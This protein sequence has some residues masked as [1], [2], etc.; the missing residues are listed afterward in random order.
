MSDL[1]GAALPRFEDERL[2]TGRGRYVGDLKLPGM[3]FVAFAR[4]GGGPSRVKHVGCDRARDLTGVVGVYTT[5]DFPELARPLPLV[6]PAGDLRIRMPSPLASDIVRFAGEAVAVVVATS[7]YAAAD[8]AAAIEIECDELPAVVDV[9]AARNKDAPLVHD[10]VQGN[11]AGTVDVGFGDIDAAFANAPVVARRVLRAA[12]MACAA[13]EPR[14]IAAVPG[15][16][17]DPVLT[18]YD[19]TQAPHAIRGGIARL[20]GLKEDQVRV[21]APDVGGGF[22]PKG[23]LYPEE[24]VLAVLALHLKRPVSWQ[25]TRRDDLMTTYQ[26]RGI[27]FDAE[28]AAEQDGRVR[29]LRVRLT[30]DLGAYSATAMIVPQNSAQ[31]LLGP[32]RWP[33]VKFTIEGIYTHKAPLT[34]LRGGGREMGVWATERMFDHLAQELG[35]DP[36]DVRALNVLQPQDFPYETGYPARGGSGTIA[37]DSG[38]YPGALE[39]CKQLVGYDK[40]MTNQE[41]DRKDGIY[42][43]VA[44]TLF[45]E[46]T[47]MASETARADLLPDGRV[48]LRIG[49]PSTGQGHATTMRQMFAARFGIE[50]DRIDYVSGDTGAVNEG[51]G[52]F[53]SRMAIIAGNAAAMAGRQLRAKVFDIAA[54]M[55]EAAPED[56]EIAGGVVKVKGVADRGLDLTEIAG[57]AAGGGTGLKVDETFTAERGS[58][59]AGGAHGVV[60][61]VDVE[62]GFVEIEKYVVVH[63]CG[64]V[65]NPLLVEG[66]VHGGVVHGLGNALMERMAYDERGRLITDSFLS[67]AMPLAQEMPRIEVEHRESPSPYNPEGIKGAGE[68]G[69]I[70]ALATVAGAIE[71]ALSPL[72]V[73]VDTLPVT[74]EEIFWMCEPLRN[75]G[76][77]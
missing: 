17:D 15:Q 46:S 68:G 16:G 37:F 57:Q 30:Q 69:T 29:G 73:W 64:T 3:L 23:R 72:E 51:V 5:A 24:V 26:G 41:T 21:V 63:D 28:I 76:Q 40:V 74:P 61:A 36:L 54:D 13:M 59:F 66:Q 52:T 49:S 20:I 9:E 2:L 75:Y 7:S 39:S 34:P 12:R 6:F 31:H 27:V 47:G 19:S 45:V 48:A 1:I 38:D 8:G 71:N 43:G 55:M 50:P 11:C 56:L 65:I 35:M 10:D 4:Y 67:Y 22:G 60:V 14:C 53:G 33:A 42:R 77:P 18:M 32:Y 58:C 44:V 62:T 25:S 70:G